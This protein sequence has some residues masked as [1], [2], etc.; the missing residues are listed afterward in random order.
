M[1]FMAATALSAYGVG[2]MAFVVNK[3]FQPS[4]F[5]S[6]RGHIVFKISIL[7][8]LVNIAGSLL[9][10]PY[11]GHVGLALATAI[12][13]WIGVI[14]MAVLLA[15]EGRLTIAALAPLLRIFISACLM[16]L[17]LFVVQ[18]V[19]A[20]VLGSLKLADLIMTIVMVITGLLS[21]FGLS[22]LFG[23]IP[24]FLFRRLRISRKA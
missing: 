20:S 22:Y 16:G 8:V 13:S 18:I 9:M 15:G 7:T 3:V 1:I 14:V 23:T 6:E 10:M 24:P 2:L 12:A 19:M 11:L 21:Y 5:A 4:F 17:V